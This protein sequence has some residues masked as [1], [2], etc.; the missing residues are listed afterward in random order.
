MLRLWTINN[1]C[2]GNENKIQL[3]DWISIKCPLAYKYPPLKK[4]VAGR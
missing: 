1:S 2:Q 4:G 3:D